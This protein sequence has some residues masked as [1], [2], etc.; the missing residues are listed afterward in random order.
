M[1]GFE[2]LVMVVTVVISVMTGFEFLVMVV[3]SAVMTVG[4]PRGRFF[5]MA[6]VVAVGVILMMPKCGVS[7][8]WLVVAMVGGARVVW[9]VAGARLVVTMASAR[10]VAVVAMVA[11]ML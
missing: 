2:F 4:K 10:V 5:V 11:M 3:T 9:L 8:E 7:V 6:L 1:A